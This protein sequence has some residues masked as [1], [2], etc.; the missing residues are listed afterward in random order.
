[1]QYYDLKKHWTKKIEPHLHDKELNDILVHDLNKLSSSRWG[2]PF[3]H[4][5]YPCVYGFHDV[6]PSRRGRQPRYWRYT[7][8]GSCHWLGNFNLRLATLAEPERPWRI[9]RSDKHSTVWDGEKML[10]EFNFLALEV[11]AQ[12]CFDL[13]FQNGTVLAPGKFRRTY[14]LRHFSEDLRPALT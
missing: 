1:M 4:G 12:E 10:F 5:M 2:K 11:P 6:A 8:F 3:I 13:A 9:I 7:Q 14:R